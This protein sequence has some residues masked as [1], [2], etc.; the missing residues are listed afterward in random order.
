MHP[1][2][3]SPAEDLDDITVIVES[4]E[5]EQLVFHGSSRDELDAKID[6]FLTWAS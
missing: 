3:S 2:R 4:D 5:H 6:D 1:F